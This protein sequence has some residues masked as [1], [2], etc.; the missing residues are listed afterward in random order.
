MPR[1]LPSYSIRTFQ[2][3]LFV[4]VHTEIGAWRRSQYGQSPVYSLFGMGMQRVDAERL[5]CGESRLLA[6]SYSPGG[7]MEISRRRRF[8]PPPANFH[9]LSGARSSFAEF[10]SSL[11]HRRFALCEN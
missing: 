5:E 9:R 1:S 11:S 2:L 7:A 8:A 4:H 3:R 10:A 6:N